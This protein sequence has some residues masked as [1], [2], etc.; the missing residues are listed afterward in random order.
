M[1][2]KKSNVPILAPIMVIIPATESKTISFPDEYLGYATSILISNLDA[3]NVATYQI[4]GNTM[5]ILSLST[6]AFRAIDDTKIHLLTIQAGAAGAC[7]VEAQVQLLV[8]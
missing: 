6:G 1:T 5:P 4:N 7:Q 8:K 3:T 2:E